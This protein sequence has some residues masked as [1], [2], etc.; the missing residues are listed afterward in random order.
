MTPARASAGEAAAFLEA[1]P[2]VDAI[3][4]VFTNL[5]GVPR[6]KRLRRA[7]LSG[8]FEQ[9][10]FLPGSI[11]VNDVRGDDVPESGL[12]WADGDADR[13]A[14]PA[15]GTLAPMP[16]AGPGAAQFIA[17]L[18]EL[19]GE[20]CR[21]D[22]R[23][24]LAEQVARLGELG[25]TPVVACELEFYLLEPEAD[26]PRP[27]AGGSLPQVYGLV[28]TDRHRGF[29]DLVNASG[30]AGGI[31]IEAAI[32][33]NAP[34]QMEIGLTHHADA[35]RAADEAV[36]FKRIV[37]GCARR[38]GMAATF[39]AKPFADTAGSGLH[40]H[41][42]L[43]DAGGANVFA[44]EAAS[45]SPLLRH[46]V[47]GLAALLPDSMAILAPNR[48][49]YRRFRAGTYA[50][51]AASWGVNN[52]TVA[53]R[54]PAGPPSTRHIEHRVAGADANP[55]LAVAAILA[56]VRHGI[57]GRIDPGPAV[58]GNGYERPA[59]PSSR[60]PTEWT[61][62]IDRL[63]A[64]AALRASLGDDVIDAY[65]SVKRHERDAYD[66]E[67]PPIDHQWLQAYA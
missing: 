2:Q 32:A 25:L 48:N 31:S 45:G 60:L 42:S 20:P 3:D 37:K 63:D 23:R 21:L 40:V 8:V 30:D 27:I 65:I 64:S 28:E 1:H 12:V 29:I 66:A 13:R 61:A 34:G 39:M 51:L 11:L 14:W 15:P 49:S 41:V 52:R 50:P 57:A 44:D 19:D 16:C 7:E 5:A 36:L 6:G 54:V 18:H 47:G 33:E 17:S 53:L 62:A 4:L 9:G 56:G 38:H 58:E 26:P 55:Y 24:I 10:R 46:A 35:L 43:L 22:P 67:V 59:D